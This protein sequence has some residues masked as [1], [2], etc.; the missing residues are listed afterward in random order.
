MSN[1]KVKPISELGLLD[2]VVYINKLIDD[3]LLIEDD[4]NII[5]ESGINVSFLD[6][7]IDKNINIVSKK[8]SIINYTILGSKNTNRVFE[9]NGELFINQISLV[10]TK[11]KLN[12]KLLA[13][14]ANCD[15]KCLSLASNM[16]S[17]FEQYVDHLMPLTISNIANVG[18]SLNNSSITFN[19]TG[20][21][22]K[23]MNN[24]KCAQ[25]SRGIVMDDESSVTALP[26]LL[27][28]EFDCF[29]NHGATIGK[30]SDDDLFYLMSRGLSKKDAFLLILQGIINPFISAIEIDEL[31][32]EIAKEV[33]NMIEM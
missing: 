13:S 19:T 32:E 24:S 22:Q 8:D 11:E 16:K 7:S 9:V 23:G 21:V 26:I 1:K 31:K 27:I 3:I 28:D 5:V 10:E 25:L 29:A 30:M 18:V 17:V 4:I 6:K 15:I 33:S 14:N 12:V 2:N 20:K